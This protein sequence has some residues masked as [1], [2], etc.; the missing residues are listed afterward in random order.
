MPKLNDI[1]L[2]EDVDAEQARPLDMTDPIEAH[3]FRVRLKAVTER[4]DMIYVKPGAWFTEGDRYLIVY[5]A[6]DG[7]ISWFLV[8]DEDGAKCVPDE[9]HFDRLMRYDQARSNGSLLDKFRQER[10][11][12]QAQS[13][14]A[15]E[16]KREEFRDRLGDAAKHLF[17]T[18]IH[19]GSDHKDK[20]DGR[21]PTATQTRR[22]RAKA[23]RTARKANRKQWR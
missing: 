20:V 8:Q 23:A 5:K 16:S 11:M 12:V 15:H 19:I 7:H 1:W 17:D 13:R 2:P 4:L 22:A 6:E 18:S 14:V 3:A 21:G 10:A 9:R